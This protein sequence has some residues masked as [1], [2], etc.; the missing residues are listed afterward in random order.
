MHTKYIQQALSAFRRK[1]ERTSEVKRNGRGRRGRRRE[2]RRRKMRRSRRSRSGK[3]WSRRRRKRK[4]RRR[5][6]WRNKR[7]GEN[8]CELPSPAY[9]VPPTIL[10]EHL[11]KLPSIKYLPIK[12]QLNPGL[13]LGTSTRHSEPTSQEVNEEKERG[14]GDR[15]M[16]MEQIL[17]DSN[18]PLQIWN[19]WTKTYLIF[20][21]LKK[22][23]KKLSKVNLICIMDKKLI[24]IINRKYW[25]FLLRNRLL[26]NGNS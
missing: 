19:G 8:F 7:E 13:V 17:H 20:K 2:K 23:F 3:I 5:R 24:K 10:Q 16:E 4:R 1:K 12:S 9:L 26:F 14:K 21:W 25:I 15:R 11:L 22:L 6:K 18:Y